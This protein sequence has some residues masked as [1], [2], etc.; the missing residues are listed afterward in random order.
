MAG[1]DSRR[2]SAL[3]AGGILLSRLSG[4]ARERALAHYFGGSA[5][6]D[7]F[8]AALRIPNVLQNLLGE[9]VLSAT[10]IPVYSR[11][12][13]DGEE[14]EAGRVAGAIAALLALVAGGL[15]LLGVVF[16]APIAAVI[17]PGFT[18]ETRELTVTLI[19][20]LTPGIGFLVLSAWCLGVLNSHRRFFLSYV[21][22]VLWNVAQIAVLVTVALTVTTDEADL[23]IALAW[24]T[25]AGSVLQFL[26]Q[27]PT[28]RSLARGL[29]LRPDTSRPGVRE[30]VRA[31]GPVV[32]GRGVVQVSAWLD[33][34]LG[35]LLAAGAVGLL[36][37]AQTLYILPV[38]LFGMSVAAAELPEL[39]STD[40]V[41]ERET[42]LERL[43]GGARRIAFFVVPTVAMY[44][45]V[46][47]LVVGALFQSGD[48]GVVETRVVWAVLGAYSLGLVA[49]TQSRLL[50]NA[51][52]AI[53]DAATP[54]R[55]AAIRVVLS[56]TVALLTMFSLDRLGMAQTGLRFL[57]DIPAFSPLPADIRSQ[58]GVLRLGAVGLGLGSAVGS[59]FEYTWLRRRLTSRIGR[60]PLG[61]GA[62]ARIA[63]ATGVAVLVALLLGPLADPLHPLAAAPIVLGPAGLAYLLTARRLG[64]D[65][66]S[67]LRRLV[68]RG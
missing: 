44:V 66:A 4:L 51:Y 32:L 39:S 64:L 8:R 28:V 2:N 5:A 19:R 42:L 29:R 31:F 55:T 17:T 61:G 68:R 50:Q 25:F 49:T 53:G 26:V 1:S 62:L 22:P 15:V 40:L 18:G 38:S 56:A 21:A 52:Y 37:F 13:A 36:G 57:G 3:V 7:A 54:A 12:L 60:V 47:D 46:G 14:E 45:V 34:L 20:I 67:D 58:G 63:S 27:L 30:A 48:F 65:E 59:W 23:A 43:S 16:A 9:G 41:A 33:T 6:L 10:M 24:G 11:L 35:S